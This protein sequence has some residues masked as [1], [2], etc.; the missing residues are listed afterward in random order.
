MG[1]D[2]QAIKF[3]GEDR[4]K[5]RDKVRRSLDA[6]SRMLREQMFATEPVL[7]GQEIEL[8]LVD[9]QRR[10]GDAQRH[11]ARSDRQSRL[12]DRGRPVQSRDQRAAEATAG[13]RAGRAGRRRSAATST[14]AIPRPATAAPAWSWSASCPPCRSRMCTRDDVGRPRPFRLDPVP[15]AGPSIQGR[16]VG[17]PVPLVPPG[18]GKL[19]PHEPISPPTY[20]NAA[21]AAF[22]EEFADQQ[23][24]G[25]DASCCWASQ[26]ALA[27]PC[28]SDVRRHRGG[29]GCDP[30]RL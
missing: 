6:L 2:I 21:Y 24:P 13:R 19:S 11:R 26:Q 22:A 3:S 16:S 15:L 18:G 7:V 27:S 20:H 30:R 4:R 5:Y 8:N 1:R 10:A 17:R 23:P 29:C 9:E 14:P 28:S 12:G 25:A